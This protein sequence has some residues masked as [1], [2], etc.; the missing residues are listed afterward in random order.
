EAAYAGIAAKYDPKTTSIL[1]DMSAATRANDW[2]LLRTA[3]QR[4]AALLRAFHSDLAVLTTPPRI[5]SAVK[6]LAVNDEDW[7]VLDDKLVAGSNAF[8]AANG[9]TWT[10]GRDRHA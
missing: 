1:N 5:S 10:A 8:I 6:R 7:A 2:T 9:T 4:H 3:F